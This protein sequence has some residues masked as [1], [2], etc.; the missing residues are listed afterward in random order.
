MSVL[1]VWLHKKAP[2]FLSIQAVPKLH[3]EKIENSPTTSDYLCK[4]FQPFVPT[5]KDN[6]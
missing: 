5:D 4:G 2:W 6:H 1:A 3:Q